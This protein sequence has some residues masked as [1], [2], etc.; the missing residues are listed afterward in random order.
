MI[1]GPLGQGGVNFSLLYRKKYLTRA[2]AYVKA[3]ILIS[4]RCL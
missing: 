3:C 2:Y 4:F 1:G